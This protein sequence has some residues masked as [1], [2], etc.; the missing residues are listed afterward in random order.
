MQG[1]VLKR[2]G[3]SVRILERHN[4]PTRPSQGAG[5]T[6]KEHLQ[7][8]FIQHDLT[9]TPLFISST[10][11]Q[12]LNLDGDVFRTQTWPIKATSWSLLYHVLRF[13]FDGL[14]SSSCDGVEFPDPQVAG[15]AIHDYGQRVTN[16]RQL[17]GGII[18]EH[19]NRHGGQESTEADLVIAADGPS[20]H[21]RKL[22]LP[23]VQRTYA[24]FVAWR[25]TVCE[26]AASEEAK[27]TFKELL[28]IYRGRGTQIVM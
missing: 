11:R 10:C 24:G 1:I 26:K 23:G 20:S 5:I 25:G 27:E 15:S 12:Y 3:H 17:D 6:T 21:I 9:N 18:V 22:L 13:G 2:L 14:R 19:V 7:E 16:L 8:Y 4:E 28:S